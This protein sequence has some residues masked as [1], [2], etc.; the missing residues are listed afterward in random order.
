[1]IQAR[2]SI[3]VKS[4]PQQVFDFVVVGFTRNYRRWSPEVQRLDILTPGP[5]RVGSR[6]R[7]V[8][9]DQG[10]RSDNTFRVVA[11]EPP[12]QIHFAESSDQFRTV[13]R[14]E[15]VGDQT[16]LTFVFELRRFELYMRPFEKLIRVAVQ[17]GSD[18]VVRNIKGLVERESRPPVSPPT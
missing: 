14:M 12:T 5:L 4:P 10:R 7:Q 18:R 8:R 13:H 15:P 16:M 11:L 9:V 6:A 1:M 17:E 3:L 2:A